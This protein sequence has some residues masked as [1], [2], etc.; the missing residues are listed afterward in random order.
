MST[1]P[2]IGFQRLIFKNI[3]WGAFRAMLARNKAKPP[4]VC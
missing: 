4:S 1:F 3:L 2:L